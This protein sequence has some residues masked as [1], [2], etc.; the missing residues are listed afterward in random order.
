[1]YVFLE[2]CTAA[3]MYAFVGLLLLCYIVI[4]NPENNR[5][6]IAFLLIK[7]TVFIGWT[8]AVNKLCSTGY[9]YISWVAAIIP[10]LIYIL[11]LMN[12]S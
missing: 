2:F 9:K 11:F 1:M 5:Y 6:D 3:K 4:K 12:F 10:H 8:F 7:A